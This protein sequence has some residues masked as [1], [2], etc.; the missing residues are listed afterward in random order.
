MSSCCV[1]PPPPV[2]P[3]DP[4]PPVLP[5]PAP[6]P[7]PPTPPPSPGLPPAT[8]GRSYRKVVTFV[9][10]VAGTVEAFDVDA[11]RTNL[12]AMIAGV[13]PSDIEVT[14]ASGSVIVTSRI[15]PRT[16]TAEVN[17]LVLFQDPVI[18]SDGFIYE[19]EAVETLINTKRPSPMTREAF[20][21]TRESSVKHES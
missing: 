10:E 8:P 3:P 20:G 15:I 14:V 9:A 17:T 16:T 7:T 13:E 4:P 2:F 11:Y 19:R 12:A 1:S 5:S 21:T 18:A 6:P